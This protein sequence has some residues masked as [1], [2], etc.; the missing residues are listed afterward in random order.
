[1][2]EVFYKNNFFTPKKALK[3]LKDIEN[4]AIN[5]N[6]IG[7]REDQIK[8]VLLNVQNLC[9]H[10]EDVKCHHILQDQNL[11]IFSETWLTDIQTN[12]GN[13]KYELQEYEATFCNVGNGKGVAAYSDGTFSCVEKV[14]EKT[15]Q[16][17]KYRTCFTHFTDK[18]V[19][20][21]I[22]G[23]YRSSRNPKDAEL[24][25]HLKRMVNYGQ[26]CIIS[27]DFN[28]NYRK[29]QENSFIKELLRMKFVQLV[30]VP[31]HRDG[32]TIDQIFL[33]RP[34]VFEDVLIKWDVFA[35]FYSDHFGLSIIINKEK[36]SFKSIESTIPD[37]LLEED[38]S[39]TTINEH[40]DDMLN[41]KDG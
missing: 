3:T 17:I 28:I 30:D 14:I 2:L 24:L 38:S 8:I 9:N 34:N 33:Y 37:Y 4:R 22:V 6:Y 26:I 25:S 20:V 7:R 40:N 5:A 15:Y 39:I 31:T 10:I 27:G 19:D 41:N 29:E 11:L 36:E 35:P 13:G 32:G 21:D 1:M 16:V 12:F 23:I 18:R